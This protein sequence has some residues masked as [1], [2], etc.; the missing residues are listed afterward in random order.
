[1]AVTPINVSALVEG[2]KPALGPQRI[3]ASLFLPETGPGETLM[4]C[5][6]GAS[7]ARSYFHPDHAGADGYSFAR[8]MGERG[9]NVLLIDHLGMGESER[10]EHAGLIG[11]QSAAAF[12]NAL[13]E[14]VLTRLSAGEWGDA[15]IRQLIGIA[16][17]MGSMVLLEWQ[18]SF[19]RFDRLA[20]LGWSNI[21]L[22]FDT[23]VLDALAAAPGY[24]STD[25]AMMRPIFH[26]E[27]V[28]LDIIEAD[29][30]AMSLTPSGLAVEALTPG[31]AR[32]AAAAITVPVLAVFGERD[33]SPDPGGEAGF[34]PNSADLECFMLAG[35]AH[36]HNFASTRTVLW[37]HLLGWA[38]LAATTPAPAPIQE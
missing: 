29:D 14:T 35:S 3:A 11:R 24:I 25:R 26:M 27:D 30:A 31:I 36:N 4:V 23:A 33:I 28:P 1:M 37:N 9:V 13:L 10:P 17:S 21:G 12:H 19:A 22:D 18:A 16:H 38:G 6:A 34:Y 2:G 15:N 7:Y 5:I 20:L 32:E 8:H